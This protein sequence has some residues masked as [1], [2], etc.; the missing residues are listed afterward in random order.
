MGTSSDMENV[1]LEMYAAGEGLGSG[2]GERKPAAKEPIGIY[3]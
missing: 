1:D 2:E 3:H